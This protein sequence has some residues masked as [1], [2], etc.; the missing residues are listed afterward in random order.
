MATPAY[1][2]DVK[3]NYEDTLANSQAYADS[4]QQI[5][6]YFTLGTQ[7]AQQ[8]YNYDISEAYANYK[9][10]QLATMSMQ[11]VGIGD[12]EYAT[13]QLQKNYQNT[14]QD[15]NNAYQ[16]QLEAIATNYTK[17]AND[18]N[19][20]ISNDAEQMANLYDY[21]IQYGYDNNN[22][23]K[24]QL[25]GTYDTRNDN[26]YN[27][28]DAG[29]TPTTETQNYLNHMLYGSDV[30]LKTGFLDYLK[31]ENSS[32]YD[33]AVNN[34]QK[35]AAT[36]MGRDLNDGYL[37]DDTEYANAKEQIKKEKNTKYLE[38]I[39]VSKLEQGKTFK[40][41]DKE[42]TVSSKKEIPSD[43]VAYY[44]DSGDV[45]S[46]VKP[47]IDDTN[48]SITFTEGKTI[49][50]KEGD[51]YYA[52][53]I[54]AVPE[55]SKLI[56]N[57]EGRTVAT[58]SDVKF[59]K[60][61]FNDNHTTDIRTFSVLPKYNQVVTYKNQKYY[62]DARMSR[63]QHLSDTEKKQYSSNLLPIGAV[64]TSGNQKMILLKYGDTAVW[65]PM[66]N[67]PNHKL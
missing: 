39:D 38:N 19:K 51:K 22:N 17:Q 44:T 64:K 2:I 30:N 11:N 20:N 5:T 21:I 27:K 26:L 65:C 10:Q 3:R 42:Y 46:N 62:V 66:S 52:Y 14:A 47:I 15:I 4:V 61:L 35:F 24:W 1:T 29:Y 7:K 12:R 56:T 54:E 59:P 53:N 6:E 16:T 18:L 58:N 37:Y 34:W 33:Y 63:A 28:T 48:G 45:Y 36:T 43:Q 57:D 8:D 13:G 60:A 67:T 49:V 23:G 31:E 40:M 9:R 50:K 32:L 41:G 55:K 25:A